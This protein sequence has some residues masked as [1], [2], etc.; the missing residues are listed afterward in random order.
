[1]SKLVY[2]VASSIDGFISGPDE[3][4]SMFVQEGNGVSRYLDD[5]KQ[6]STT[7]MGRGTYEF[8]YRFG[9][10]P[11]QP[12]YPHMEHH[13]FSD[14]LQ[15]DNPSPQ[16]HVEK[17]ST[18]RVIE[19]R[20]SSKT[21]VYVCGGGKFAGW[22]LENDL[23]DIMIIKLNPIILGTGIRLIDNP[24]VRKKWILE[25]SEQYENGLLFITYLRDYEHST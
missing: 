3:D 24:D 12:A 15:F 25:K 8:G 20:D 13:V 9:L 6:F 23:I 19:I 21:D 18:K 5:L 17:I 14:S 2:Y 1:M 4:I 11:G 16:V 22:L 10:K 7:I